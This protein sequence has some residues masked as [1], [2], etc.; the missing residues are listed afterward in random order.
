ME[1]R[2]HPSHMLQMKVF[3][4]VNNVARIIQMEEAEL[5]IEP[6]S[7]IPELIL[8][9]SVHHDG[10]VVEQINIYTQSGFQRTLPQRILGENRI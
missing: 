4:K 9:L 7:V 5:K 8:F 2:E 3:K 10:T 1:D 6:I